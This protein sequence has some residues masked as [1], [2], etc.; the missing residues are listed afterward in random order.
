MTTPHAHLFPLPLGRSGFTLVGTLSFLNDPDFADKRY[1]Q[2]GNVFRTHL[3]GRPTIYPLGA[4]A[5]RFLLLNKNQ[6][7]VTS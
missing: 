5:V 4:D 7:F 3:L 6:Y 1:E 2:Y